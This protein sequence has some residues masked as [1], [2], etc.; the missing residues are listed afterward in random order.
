MKLNKSRAREAKVQFGIS[1][2]TSLGTI[3]VDTP[4]RIITFYILP[5]DT[6]FLLSL[7]DLDKSNTRFNNH[8]NV[9]I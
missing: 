5:A 3:D 6:L 7:K 9:L 8:A 1:K 4:I 2:A